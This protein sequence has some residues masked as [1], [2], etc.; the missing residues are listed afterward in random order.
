MAELLGKADKEKSTA[1]LIAWSAIADLISSPVGGEYKN[2]ITNVN[3]FVNVLISA[4][5]C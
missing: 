3:F 2:I 5:I 4:S 1:G